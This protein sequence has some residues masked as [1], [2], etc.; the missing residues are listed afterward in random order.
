MF[1]QNGR[2]PQEPEYNSRATTWV[3][4]FFN[5]RDY[6]C[7]DLSIMRT[8][9]IC[10]RTRV[11]SITAHAMHHDIPFCISI[12]VPGEHGD[13]E[14]ILAAAEVSAEYLRAQVTRGSVHINRAL[15]FRR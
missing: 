7:D 12:Q 1:Y 6:R 13:K 3:N 15:L 10:I 14:S 11:V 8:V 2:L 9:I 5:A 4:V